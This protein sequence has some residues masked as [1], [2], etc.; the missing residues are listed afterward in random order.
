MNRIVRIAWVLLML[1]CS[2]GVAWSQ[3]LAHPVAAVRPPNGSVFLLT[4]ENIVYAVNMTPAGGTVA[5][6]FYFQTYGSPSDMT[7]GLV[8][9]QA[10]LFIASSY[11]LGGT[12]HGIVQAFTTDGHLLNSWNTSHIVGG[13]TFDSTSQLVYFTSADSAEVYSIAPQNNAAPRYLNGVSG[14]SHLG[15]IAMDTGRNTLYIADLD[16]GSVFSMDMKTKKT[17]VLGKVGTPQ[18]LLMA[19]DGSTLIVADNARQQIL[20]LP[21]GTVTSTAKPL[22]A[23]NFF[24]APT[25][26][27][28]WDATHLIVADQV[29]G[30]VSLLDATGKILCFVPLPLK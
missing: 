16:Q 20:S 15:S 7:Y 22:T 28:W 18:A 3:A 29:A 13:L 1:A 4:A 27:A 11:S 26:L 17:T 19:M 23:A 24:K 5:G 10:E 6:K 8:N 12:V 2:K 30:R 21:I 14:G 9:S 25:G